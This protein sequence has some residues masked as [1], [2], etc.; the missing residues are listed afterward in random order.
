MIVISFIKRHAAEDDTS[1]CY[2]GILG[3]NYCTFCEVWELSLSE[4]ES[5]SEVQQQTHLEMKRKKL[6]QTHYPENTTV[7]QN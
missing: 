5:E 2:E 7:Q 6:E 1:L 3:W 4:D